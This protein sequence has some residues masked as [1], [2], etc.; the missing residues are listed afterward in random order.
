MSEVNLCLTVIPTSPPLPPCPVEV[1]DRTG[2][3][4]VNA[5]HRWRDGRE[6]LAHCR[7]CGKSRK[8]LRTAARRLV[9]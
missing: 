5:T 4:N 1:D 6:V 9:T 7:L 8:E 3:L 2:L